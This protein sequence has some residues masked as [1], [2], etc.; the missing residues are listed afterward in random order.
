MDLLG[1]AAIA[2]AFI[3]LAL[4]PSR[5]AP[6]GLDPVTIAIVR[7]DGILVPFAAW[8]GKSWENPWPVPTKEAD[9]PITLDELPRRWWSKATGPVDR[10]Y[11]SLV[12][13]TADVVKT[14]SPAWFPAHC[15]QG[16]GLRTTL[17]VRK[18]V[19]PLRIQPYP[20]IG[21]AMSRR[22]P[23][24]P[25]EPLDPASPT[26]TALMASLPSLVDRDE[27][28]EAKRYQMTSRW[29]HP[30]NEAGRRRIPIAIEALYRAPT[31]PGESVV[32]FEAVKRYPPVAGPAKDARD[33]DRPRDPTRTGQ[34]REQPCEVATFVW[35]WA[36][37]LD[38]ATKISPR[39]RH[40][41]MTSCDFNTVDVMLP[42]ASMSVGTQRLWIVQLSGWGR[43][44]Y[45]LIDPEIA[46]E[47]NVVWNV[48]GGQCAPRDGGA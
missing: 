39:T 10:W 5:A 24:A 13:G 42:L 43:E 27:D 31:A 14:T 41:T 1:R 44:R 45:V 23:L 20:K 2:A 46:I 33:A 37:V 16:I 9:T 35:G 19:P 25:I 36:T 30:Y 47:T 21:V 7:Q 17:A 8:T 38:G 34:Q 26:G 15:Q 28:E 6:D 29:K 11:A 4:V 18:P 3:P 48:P 40:T 22:L 32:Y 12:D